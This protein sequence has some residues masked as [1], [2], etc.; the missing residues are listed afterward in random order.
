MIQ[1]IQ[2]IYLLVATGL[3]S[4]LFFTNLVS[5]STE[6]TTHT[7]VFNGIFPNDQ[8]ELNSVISTLAFTILLICCVAVG[9]AS[10]FLYKRRLLQ[11]RLS[12]LNIGLHLGLCGLIYFFAKTA[13][14]ELG[15]EY[16]FHYPVVFPLIS[17]ILIILAIKAIGRDEALIRSM[18][19]IR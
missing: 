3:T 11:I 2:S 6:M 8:P 17:V 16:S 7:M 5:F 9:I 4:S 10:I 14:R 18:D 13:S 19:R 15:A 12:A 1:R